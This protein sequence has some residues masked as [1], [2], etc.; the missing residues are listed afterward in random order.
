MSI[1]RQPRNMESVLLLHCYHLGR[2]FH[3]FKLPYLDI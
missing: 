3:T 2:D 1:N